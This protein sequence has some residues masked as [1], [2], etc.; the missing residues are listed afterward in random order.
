M[1]TVLN[2]VEVAYCGR[3]CLDSH[4]CEMCGVQKW[5]EI[6]SKLLHTYW[7][8]NCF[9]A[10]QMLCNL[11]CASHD[12]VCSCTC[13]HDPVGPCTCW[14]WYHVL[15]Y[16]LAMM[17]YAM[18]HAGYCGTVYTWTCW[19]SCRVPLYL[20]TVMICAWYCAFLYVLATI[21]Y[22]LVFACQNTVYTCMCL[23]QYCVLLY[24]L[25]MMLC[26]PVHSGHDTVHS[27]TW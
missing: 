26:A 25:V 22:S 27:C 10:K 20:V 8:Q 14:P 6:V 19:S 11:V 7:K 9:S 3:W 15:L 23:P 4:S 2:A 1:I 24:M 17:L 21:L 16:V 5:P 18:V 12:T 13:W